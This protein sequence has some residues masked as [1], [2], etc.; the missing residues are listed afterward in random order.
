MENAIAFENVSFAYGEKDVIKDVSLTI[1]KGQYIAIV[2]K[3][4]S[5]KSTLAKLMNG[6]LTPDNGTISIFGLTG[7][8]EETQKEIRRRVGMVFQNPDNQIVASIVEED[9]AFGPENLGI[10]PL[11]IRKRVD[12]ALAT[13]GMTDYALRAPHMLS[14]GQ[15]QRVAISGVLAMEPEVVIFD[16]STSML[17]PQGREEILSTMGMLHEK[18]MTVIHITHGMEEAL[19]AERILVMEAGELAI[20]CPAAEL[21]TRHE[22]AILALGLALPFPME[23]AQRLKERG[24]ILSAPLT[25]ETLVEELVCP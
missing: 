11:E 8:A 13:V 22:K 20:A 1:E 24:I 4:G 18:G 25:L 19:L 7:T 9:V 16:E 14:G 17:D 21:F 6:L 3:N 12:D 15:K 23:M 5:G 2:G 10:A